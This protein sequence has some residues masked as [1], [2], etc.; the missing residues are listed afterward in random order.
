MIKIKHL[1]PVLVLFGLIGASWP[2]DWLFP[3]PNHEAP[4]TKAWVEKEYDIIHT[5]A[6]S[7]DQKVL[8]LGL[9]ALAR[10]QSQGYVR[11]E[12]L[13]II[14]YSKPSTEKR[15][16]VFDLKRGRIVMNTWVSHGKN[17]G[18]LNANSFSNSNGSLKSSI[19]VF[20]TDQ[21]YIGGHGISLRMR[22]LE[23]GVNDHAYSRNIVFHGAAYVN[24]R[25]ANQ[26]GRMGLSW[27]CPA[28]STDNIK[29]LVDTIK[30][31]TVVF[32]YYPDRSWLRNSR[33]IA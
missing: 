15:L 8:R 20:V 32:A 25:M 33:Y 27:G 21:P 10:V 5:K 3:H 6:P 1:F 26:L 11:K 28:V 22:G 23:K 13:T 16:W 14:D 2:F 18:S 31:N 19:G 12:L 7:L 4:G 30:G 29:T 24:G 17:S 9:T